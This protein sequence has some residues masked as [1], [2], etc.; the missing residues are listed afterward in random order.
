[1]KNIYYYY[2]LTKV[3]SDS[4]K[5][6]FRDNTL[7]TTVKKCAPKDS[8]LSKETIFE[9]KNSFGNYQQQ[10]LIKKPSLPLTRPQATQ[11]IRLS[12]EM[13]R[14]EWVAGFQR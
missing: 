5:H 12:L 13:N 4:F 2:F 8:I 6:I 11:A 10:G 14:A 1:M 3:S 9:A 7:N